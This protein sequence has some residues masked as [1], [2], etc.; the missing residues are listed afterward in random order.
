L[1]VRLAADSIELLVGNT[2]LGELPG[3]DTSPSLVGLAVSMTSGDR[4]QVNFG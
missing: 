1:E 3:I 4:V 2:S